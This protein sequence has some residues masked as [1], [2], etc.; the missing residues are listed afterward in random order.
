MDEASLLKVFKFSILILRRLLR[1]RLMWSGRVSVSVSV[2]STFVI[3]EARV[4]GADSQD[5]C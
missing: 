2:S 1:Q 3:I 4:F 5:V